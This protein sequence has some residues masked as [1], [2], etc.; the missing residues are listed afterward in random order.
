MAKKK[1]EETIVTK[2]NQN[3]EDMKAK[4]QEKLAELLVLGKKKKNIME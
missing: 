3:P 1:E 2:E 4:F